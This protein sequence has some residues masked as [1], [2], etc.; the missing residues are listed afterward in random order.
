[1]PDRAE[2]FADNWA[3]LKAELGWLDR[4]L[5]MA[6]ARQRKEVQEINR[7]S[8]S[9]ADQATSHWWKGLVALEGPIAYDEYRKSTTVEGAKPNVHQQLE[10]RIRA[11]SQQGIGLGLPLLCD[12]LKLTPFEK[13]VILMT[14]APEINR[15]YIQIYHYL[16]GEEGI[17]KTGL[18]TVDLA[19]RLFCR[20]DQEWHVARNR[21]MATSPLIQLQLLQVLPR[22][23][24]TILNYSLKLNEQLVE[25]LLAERPT[26]DALS[27]LLQPIVPFVPSRSP[28]TESSLGLMYRESVVEWSSLILPPDLIQS[29]QKL[30]QRVLW[31]M[32]VNDEWGFKSH[33]LTNEPSSGTVTLLV[34]PPG[35]GKTLAAT[36][37]ATALKTPLV[38]VNLAIVEPTQYLS[39]LQKIE[40]QAPTILLI[41]SAEY[42]LRRSADLPTSYLQNLIQ[43]RLQTGI[44]LFSVSL[45]AAVKITWQ[46]QMDLI[47]KFPFPAAPARLRLWQQA[48]P[49]QMPLDPTLDWQQ[50]AQTFPLTGREIRAIAHTAAF[51]LA[52]SGDPQL[53]LE[54]LLSA[55]SHHSREKK[56][57]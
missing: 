28:I 5:M 54:H 19:L 13:N 6:V 12:R 47:L 40:S 25:Y 14:L 46:H 24:D 15:R 1:M 4:V 31:Q 3:Y 9:R 56:N 8:S 7:V 23:A 50:I 29:L 52:A 22:Q 49:P 44:T 55:I 20:N 36:A 10:A 37:I 32:K 41:K 30:S 38:V 17:S 48:F 35:T 39:L 18:P 53:R 43:Q 26:S 11:S 33:S 42:W 27:T 2:G 45:L 57:R 51:N 16:Q 21:L 34:G